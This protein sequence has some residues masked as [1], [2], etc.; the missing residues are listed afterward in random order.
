[1]T[2]SN[3]KP[4][5]VNIEGPDD[6]EEFD[7]M[8]EAVER[9]NE[10]NASLVD[11]VSG[12]GEFAPHL[13]AVPWRTKTFLAQFEQAE[14]E[15]EHLRDVVGDLSSELAAALAVIEQIK[16]AGDWLDAEEAKAGSWWSPAARKGHLRTRYLNKIDAAIA[17]YEEEAT[18]A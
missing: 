7:T 17:H 18:D 10:I 9:A 8:R 1:M 14:G 11:T 2:E 15:R 3:C 6:I 12:G 16:A 4:F 5:V 13:W